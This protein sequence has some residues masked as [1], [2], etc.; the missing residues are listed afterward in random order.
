[1][2]NKASLKYTLIGVGITVLLFT[3]LFTVYYFLSGYLYEQQV[4]Q[5]FYSLKNVTNIKYQEAVSYYDLFNTSF[6]DTKQNGYMNQFNVTYVDEKNQ[7]VT[8]NELIDEN[9]NILIKKGI[10]VTAE[11]TS[12]NEQIETLDKLNHYMYLQITLFTF[13]HVIDGNFYL[14]DKLL[15]EQTDAASSV[16]T[17][18]L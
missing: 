6:N 8:F 3:I 15:T 1:M 10:D 12:I 11:R 5:Q 9:S 18:L 16:L 4:M 7:L 17:L 2:N 14:L 13:F